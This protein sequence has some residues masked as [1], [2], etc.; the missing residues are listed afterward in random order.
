M[1]SKKTKKVKEPLAE[2]KEKTPTKSNG[3]NIDSLEATTKKKAKKDATLLTKTKIS[4]FETQ[5]L[6]KVWKYATLEHYA[7]ECFGND[8]K[9]EKFPR[10][11]NQVAIII[12]DKR[13]PEEGY[14]TVN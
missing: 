10:S 6:S 12:K 3:K 1:A 14:F 9:F 2:S 5:V 4:E 13:V 7:I 8:V 11:F